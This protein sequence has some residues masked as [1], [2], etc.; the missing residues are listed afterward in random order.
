MNWNLGSTLLLTSKASVR[1]IEARSSRKGLWGSWLGSVEHA[2]KWRLGFTHFADCKTVD[3]AFVLV[4][5]VCVM[6]D[7]TAVRFTNH[8]CSSN[9][10]VSFLIYNSFIFN[11]C[12]FK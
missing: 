9:S 12:F 8:D 11:H 4:V 1:T 2:L 6:F 5:L 10:S 7:D 3:P